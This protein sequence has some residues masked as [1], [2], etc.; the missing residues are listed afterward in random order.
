MNLLFFGSSVVIVAFVLRFLVA[1]HKELRAGSSGSVAVR[2]IKSEFSAKRKKVLVMDRR[3]RDQ[4]CTR[5]SGRGAVVMAIAATLTVIPLHGQEKADGAAS[6]QEFRE[7]QQLVQQLQAKVARLEEQLEKQQPASVPEEKGASDPTAAQPL[8]AATQWTPGERGV[9]DFFQDTTINLGI[10]GYY[11]YNFNR[12]VGRVNLLR[13]YDVSSNS[14]SLNQANLIVERAADVRA[15]RR[16]GAS[17]DLQFGQ[18]TE[19]LQGSAVNQLRPQVYRPVFQVYGT[20]IFPLGNGLTV[21]FGKW[22]SAMGIE[23]NYTKDQI[24]YSRSYLFNFLPFYHMG[25][26]ATYQFNNFVTLTYAVVNGTQQTEDFN[27]FKSQMMFLTLHPAKTVSWNI[28]YHSGQE[29]RDV[30]PALNPEFPGGPTQPGL[31]DSPIIPTPNPRLHIF[32]SYVTWTASPKLTLAAEADYVI[33]RVS[34]QSTPTHVSGGA[35]YA[36]Y[37]LTPKVALAARTEY[38]SDRG[39]LF[40]GRTQALKETTLTYEY[41]FADGFLVRTEWRRDFSNQPFFLTEQVG[42]RKKE[43]NTATLG[44]IWWWGRKQGSW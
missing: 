25:V 1:L 8:A 40:S 33:N 32:D 23:N 42:V 27:S 20:Y 7:L 43:Q 16:F 10:D 6:A 21:D 11:G 29:Q 41:K 15:G 12:P 37:Q 4:K 22:A 24:N 38:L 19:T 28:N 44:L 35:G 5:R 31:P 9:L 34:S 17:L 36:R 14:F 13:A 2:F 39:G 18:A 30:V 3:A 26:R